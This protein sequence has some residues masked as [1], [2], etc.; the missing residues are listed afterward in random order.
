MEYDFRP[1]D[2]RRLVQRMGVPARDAADV[3]QTAVTNVLDQ[4]PRLDRSRELGGYVRRAVENEART[5]LRRA[6]RRGEVLTAFEEQEPGD[7]RPDPEREAMQRQRAR[8]V[9]LVLGQI[10][11]KLRGLVADFKLAE[12]SVE[13]IAAERG[14]K[15]KTVESQI[16]RGLR[17][18]VARLAR[19]QAEERWRGRDGVP[20]WLLVLAQPTEW[21]PA[22]PRCRAAWRELSRWVAQAA[23]ATAAVAIPAGVLSSDDVFDRLPPAQLHASHILLAPSGAPLIEEGAE[24]PSEN[25]RLTS[26]EANPVVVTVRA[27]P[28]EE[29]AHATRRAEEG[30]LF[31]VQ[32]LLQAGDTA[33][34]AE[35]LQLLEEHRRRYRNGRLAE[36]RRGL[37]ARTQ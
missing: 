31:K 28:L 9:H 20:C 33:S 29:V 16:A 37:L 2:L 19:W 1:D 4:H 24:S 17:E 10:D 25:A 12:K 34:V 30:L 7:V 35:A 3:V 11:E 13:E 27:E 15:K 32:A 36:A 8:R 23:A 14:L 5:Y 22:G 18:F 6:R 26:P 21:P